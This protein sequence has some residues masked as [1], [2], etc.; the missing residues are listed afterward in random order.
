MRVQQMFPLA[1]K[2]Q[3]FR[4]FYQPKVNILSGEMEGAEA[5]CRWLHDGRI[6]PTMEF[7]PLLE[8][9][10]DIC[11]LDLYMLEHVCMDLRRWLDEGKEIV[12]V[13]VNF[14][15][16]NIMNSALSKTITEIVDRYQ[17]PHK[18]I[19]IELTETTP[20]V[21]FSDLKRITGALHALGFYTSV[22]D[23]GVGF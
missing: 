23:F 21:A 11:K 19:E 14:S 12:R 5:L 2:A 16:K 3:E 9:T 15:R 18:Y 13:S 1:I 22:D 4:P 17:I 6:V 20:D 8:Q 10:S 7:I